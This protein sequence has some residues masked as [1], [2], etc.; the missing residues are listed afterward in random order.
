M[1][2]IIIFLVT[3]AT[4]FLPTSSVFAAAG[5]NVVSDFILTFVKNGEKEASSFTTSDVEIPEIREKTP[6]NS[7]SGLKSPHENVKVSICYFESRE[8]EPERIAFIWEVT[9]NKEKVTDIRVVYDGSNPFVDESKA[10]RE[11]QE[12]MKTAVLAP[13]EF[14]FEITHIDAKIANHALLL[15]YRNAELEGLVEIVVSPTDSDLKELKDKNDEYYTLKNGKKALF[16]TATNQLVF[17]HK[18]M[19]YSISVSNTGN[20]D[21]T[22]EECL[23]IA[24]S[25]IVLN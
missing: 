21:R 3:F 24:N 4:L 20:K 19:R 23:N 16:S 10:I 13:A 22:V 8:D 7:C 5:G 14:P 6:I 25:M 9:S 18:K 15:K 1:K 11:Y 17:Q 12:K 2:R